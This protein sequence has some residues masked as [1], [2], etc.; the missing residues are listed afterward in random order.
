VRHVVELLDDAFS[1][2]LNYR[3][4]H[5]RVGYWTM[6]IHAGMARLTGALP[7]GRKK[8]ENF[9]SGITPVSG[10]T[11]HLTKALNSVAGLPAA[12]LSGGVALNLKFT[13]R[14]GEQDAMAKDLAARVNAFVL[15]DEED[16]ARPGGMEIQ[17]NIT[18]RH[19]FE[20]LVNDPLGD[21]ELKDL[22]V[23]VSGYTAYFKDL[24]P[25]MQK[26]IIE[27]TEYLLPKGDA[28]PFQPFVLAD[29]PSG[30]DVDKVLG[31]LESLA[32]KVPPGAVRRLIDHLVNGLT[33]N[34]L[35]GLL[36]GMELAFFLSGSFLDTRWLLGDIL[37]DYR[38]NIENFRGRYLFEARNGAEVG[39]VFQAGEMEVV[40][41]GI[42]DWDI[43]I[44]FEDD[45]ALLRFLLK[46]GDG[47]VMDEILG[48]TVETEGNL[49]YLFKFGFIVRDLLC[50]F[51]IL[52][53][54][55]D[56]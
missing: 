19:I 37:K 24:N 6:T 21:A 27:R 9:A 46:G 17:F 23:R 34:V 31:G 35:E 10:V 56:A 13:P 29:L 28:R 53:K 12:A 36:K 49:N 25:Q 41:D 11:P 32:E 8:G 7:N 5:Y 47:E 18:D 15:K 2:K 40:D 3:G 45:W 54:V 55:A 14:P 50:R 22:L 38:R 1:H 26:E 51:G 43:K 44:T 30:V 33:D 52:Q 20:N 39:V 16:P 4:G 48:H 42:E